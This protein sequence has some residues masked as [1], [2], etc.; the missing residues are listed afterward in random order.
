MLTLK[1]NLRAPLMA[2]SVLALVLP[3]GAQLYGGPGAEAVLHGGPNGTGASLPVTGPVS[4]LSTY[5]FNDQASSIVINA[6]SWELCSDSNFR[7]RCEVLAAS[8]GDLSEIRLNNTVSSIRPVSERP[9]RPRG[10][11]TR[12]AQG[13]IVFHSETG[14]RGQAVALNASL[15]DFNRVSFNDRARSVEVNS[16]VWRLCSDGG[17]SGACVYVD[18]SVRNLGD[19]GLSGQ[20]SSAELSPYPQ[21]PD[22]YNIALFQHGN[23]NG[24]FLGFDEGVADLSRFNFN[25]TASSVVVTRGTWL[26]CEDAEYRG[27]CELVDASL[28]DLAVIDLNDRVTSF[29]R[30]DLGRDGPDRRRGR[31]LGHDD[32]TGS[33]T[34]PGRRRGQ[35]DAG[36]AGESTVFFPAPTSRGRRIDNG[37]GAAT[38]F[39]RDN[40]FAEAAYKARGPVLSDVLCR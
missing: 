4:D 30:Y 7:G 27:D 11:D 39:C 23:Y 15:R 5:R 35:T 6:G 33:I 38:R 34:L 40:G 18:R 25:D 20:I 36:I 3:A 31:G 17:F 8:L 1:S 37:A 9:S 2:A 12:S 21:A 16:G 26:L 24:K 10:G 32:G 22:R 19:I 14:L 29:R 13:A 28:D